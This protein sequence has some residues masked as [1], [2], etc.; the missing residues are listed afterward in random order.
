MLALL[1]YRTGGAAENMATDFLLLQR[2]ATDHPMLRHYEWRRP[3][4]TFGY[5]QK[6]AFIQSQLPTD[7]PFDLCRRPTGGGLVD[8]R[9]DWTYSLIVPLMLCA[10]LSVIVGR[11]LSRDS[12]Y[13]AE[14]AAA[15]IRLGSTTDP[16]DS[17]GCADVS[18]NSFDDAERASS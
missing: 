18:V 3:A 10:V 1:P 14:L 16:S 15:G 9:E 8:H 2:A 11:L 12:V 6:R 17:S 13:T 5:S 7:A 4:F